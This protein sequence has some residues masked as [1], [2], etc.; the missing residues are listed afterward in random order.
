MATMSIIFIVSFRNLASDT[1]FLFDPKTLLRGTVLVSLLRLY[2]LH[3]SYYFQLEFSLIL[4]RH[5]A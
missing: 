1:K 5:E 3:I 2:H 4:P